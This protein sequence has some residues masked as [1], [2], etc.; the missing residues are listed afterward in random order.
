MGTVPPIV[1]MGLLVWPLSAALG[2]RC[3]LRADRGRD[4]GVAG[5]GR[6]ADQA[7]L[8]SCAADSARVSRR[9]T[10]SD[11]FGAYPDDDLPDGLYNVP[12]TETIRDGRRARR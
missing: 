7:S 3:R 4:A 11:Y 10:I 2:M 8:R 5:P 9:G 6:V 12:P 1:A